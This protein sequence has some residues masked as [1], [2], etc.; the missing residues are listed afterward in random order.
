MMIIT[1]IRPF[2]FAQQILVFDEN[3]KIIDTRETS[4]KDLPENLC[5]LVKKYNCNIIKLAGAKKYSKGLET[6][7]N[8]LFKAKYADA[9]DFQLNIECI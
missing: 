9:E 5:A 8:A 1:N 3:N 7:I 4:I 6:K 2:M